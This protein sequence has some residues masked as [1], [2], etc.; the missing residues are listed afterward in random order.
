MSIRLC[1]ECCQWVFTRDGRCPD[2]QDALPET[3]NPEESDGRFRGVVGEVLGRM[4]HVR[5]ARRK[6]P[7]DGVFY[8]TANGLFFLPYRTVTK[9]RLVEQS[10][11][12]PMWTIASILWSP[13]MFLSP[14]LKRRELRE[15]D[16]IEIEA[17]RLGKEDLQLLPDFL[18]RVPGTFFLPT[19]DIRAITQKRGQWIVERSIG[20]K[21]TIQPV[22]DG[23]F[24]QAIQQFL[25]THL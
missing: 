7:P 10:A 20:P 9:R 25:D 15:K 1:Q 4:G 11:A 22:A 23:P 5:V 16:F 19:R 13:L 21:I 8:G 12:S 2:C 14:F 3:I 18:S 17:I 6:L 24:A